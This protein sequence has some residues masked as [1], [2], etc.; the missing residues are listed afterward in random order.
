VKLGVETSVTDEG[1]GARELASTLE[2]RGFESF[3]VTEHSHVPLHYETPWPGGKPPREY[4][5]LLDPFV[6]LTAAAC[7]TERIKLGIGV[8]LVIQRDPITTA[9]EVASLDLVSGGR[10]FFGVGAGWRREEM[11]NHGTNPKTRTPLMRDRVLA[12]KEIWTEDEAEFHGEFVDFGPIRQWPKP[13]Q[14]PHPP[15]LVGGSGPTVFE[16]IMEYG[17]GWMPRSAEVDPDT[18]AE[19]IAE[20]D[21]LA[22]ERGRSPVPVTV[23]GEEAD[24]ERVEA[25]A[26]AGVERVVFH[27]P[28]LPEEETRR[29]IDR[30]SG[31]IEERSR[32]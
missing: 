5:R 4:T 1:V 2:E 25:Y 10:F 32:R 20:L 24:A 18:A 22:K 14:K 26:E 3:F 23:F 30:I 17:D 6:A 13:L 16:R 21:R 8:C 9:K 28:T 29:E 19:D 31:E 15:V 7:A 12:M 11:R 27:L